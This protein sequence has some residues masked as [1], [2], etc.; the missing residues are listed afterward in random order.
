MR[1]GS[2]AGGSESDSESRRDPKYRRL[3]FLLF[4]AVWLLSHMVNLIAV[5]AF[6]FVVL[7]A[8]AVVLSR[9]KRKR[10]ARHAGVLV[11]G[12]IGRSPRS[13]FQA[14]S[15]SEFHPHGNVFMIGYPGKF[16]HIRNQDVI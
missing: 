7:L 1:H 3:L 9:R 2:A 8:V 13:Q 11:V 14:L 10:T 15:L 4:F 16:F 12:E 6:C 5:L